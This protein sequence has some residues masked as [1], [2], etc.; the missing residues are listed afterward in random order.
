M[1]DDSLLD[2]VRSSMNKRKISEALQNT[3][4]GG[5]Y[6]LW[7][8]QQNII[9]AMNAE[10]TEAIAAIREK[11]ADRLTEAQNSY[12][13]WLQLLTAGDES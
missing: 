8:E 9:E 5:S 2:Q 7:L 12:G 11:Y 13:T 4:D 1:T 10:I 3:T 6:D